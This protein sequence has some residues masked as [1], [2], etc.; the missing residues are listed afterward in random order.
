TVNALKQLPPDQ[1]AVILYRCVFG[2]SLDEVAKRME[3]RPGN[4]SALQFRAHISL[5]RLL[6]GTAIAR[7]SEQRRHYGR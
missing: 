5:A 6:D 7:R 1:R 2:D 4:I 3:K